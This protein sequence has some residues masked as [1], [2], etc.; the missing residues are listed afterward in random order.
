MSA[1]QEVENL[2]EKMNWHWRNSMRVIRFFTFDARAALPLPLL[3]YLYE[4]VNN[5]PRHCNNA[6]FPFAGTK[7]PNLSG[8]SEKLKIWADR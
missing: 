4:N 5:H 8:C 6:Y 1:A 7:R 2:Q 3:L